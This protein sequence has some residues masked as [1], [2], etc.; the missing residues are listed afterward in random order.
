[1]VYFRS[2]QSRYFVTTQQPVPPEPVPQRAS[3]KRFAI[4]LVAWVLATPGILLSATA[5]G[6]V[7][8]KGDVSAIG[9]MSIASLGAWTSL[10][11]MT[12][13]WLQDRRCHWVWPLMGTTAGAPLAFVSAPMFLYL[14]A[15]P[16]AAYLVFW[17]LLSSRNDGAAALP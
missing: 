4:A 10:A 1:M 9:I 3:G 14:P 7:L 12:V 17:H 5:A 6:V 11:V 15:V 16:L 13:R 2:V 8:V